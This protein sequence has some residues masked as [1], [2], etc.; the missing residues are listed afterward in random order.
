MKKLWIAVLF[1]SACAPALA[2]SP[3]AGSR[4]DE[5]FSAKPKGRSL[6]VVETGEESLSEGLNRIAGDIDLGFSAPDRESES[7]NHKSA[8]LFA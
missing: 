2:D 6:Y 1:L 3:L 8:F 7:D 4:L 5:E